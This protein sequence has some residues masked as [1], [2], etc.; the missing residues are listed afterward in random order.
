MR[1]IA[2]FINKIYI[3]FS[4]VDPNTLPSATRHHGGLPEAY[5]ITL[6]A[7]LKLPKMTSHKAKIQEDTHFRIMRVLQEN[8]KLI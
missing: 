6:S 7:T 2:T 4:L 1:Y 8:P 3:L 5:F